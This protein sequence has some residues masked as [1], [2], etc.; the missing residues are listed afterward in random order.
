MVC[1]ANLDSTDP[2]LII[3]LILLQETHGLLQLKKDKNAIIDIE[4]LKRNKIRKKNEGLTKARWQ[5]V[6]KGDAPGLNH[7]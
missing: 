2:K 7:C 1:R 4:R 3:L 5:E 6:Y